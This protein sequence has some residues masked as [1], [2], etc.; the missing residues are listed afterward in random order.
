MLPKRVPIKKT[1]TKTVE[2][3]RSETVRRQALNRRREVERR[4]KMTQI[5][6]AL[7]RLS[8]KFRRVNIPRNTF[9]VGT[10]TS[11]NDR[12]LSVR[13]SRK[14]IKELQDI[15]KKTWEQRVE[16]GGSIPFTLSNT[17]NYVRFSTPTVSTNQQLA[18]VTPTQEDMTQYIVYHTH[19]VPEQ[20]RTLFTYPSGTDFRTY[21]SY[22]PTIQANII[23]ENQG[24]YIIDLIETNM[25]KPNPDE[26]VAEFNRFLSSREFQ[27]VSVNWSN[28]EY[29]QTT[30]TQ[31][32][33]AVNN[34]IDP[35]MRRKFG[36]SVKY[37]TWDQ[38]GEITLLDKNVIMNI[39]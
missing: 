30:P 32:K 16:Y 10:V 31:W 2:K 29:F 24:Y 8:K 33:R 34:Y 15:Y 26:V 3:R 9:N 6:A 5:N 19:P 7:N 11:G 35:I 17:R 23:L 36:I 12:Y 13:L 38:L 28:L 14:T 27:R 22:Y 39:G 18:S 1:S 21:I 20:N 4:R 37:Y 25:N